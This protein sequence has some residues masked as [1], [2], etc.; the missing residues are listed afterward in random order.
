[1]AT[2]A[3]AVQTGTTFSAL[4]H[5]NYRLYFTGQ[6]I[7]SAGMWMQSIAQGWLVF[8]LT[9]SEMALGIVA[10]A[11]GI[12]SLLLSPFAGVVVDRFP[13]RTLL[14]CT[15]TVQMTLAFVLAFLVFSGTV[16]VWHIVLMAFLLGV[17]NSV[18]AP[19]RQSFVKD[20]VGSEDMSSGITLNSM[21]INGARIVGPAAAGVLLV[22]VGA[23]WCFLINGVSVLATL[24]CMAIMHVPKTVPGVGRGSPIRQMREGVHF[25][26]YHQT[27]LPL[28]LLA[29]VVSVFAVNVMTLLPAFAHNVLHA[30]AH[31]LSM[32]TSAQGF[33]AL[34]GALL[35]GMLVRR[36]GRGRVTILTMFMLSAG[37]VVLALTSHLAASAF[38]TA[39]I[40]FSM[41][42]FYVNINCMI[43]NEVPDAFRGRVMA[44][45]TLTFLGLTPLGALAVG[46][47]ADH[48][49]TPGALALYGL[50]NGVLGLL[51]VLRWRAVERIA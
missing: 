26:R 8:Q 1:M 18:D 39:L 49:G 40:G 42:I 28:L 32:L 14:L 15:Q 20:M 43:Q 24:F 4:R 23:A 30:P 35:L 34:C 5:P 2:L 13:R 10:C 12:A 3:Q 33:G 45:Y 16:Q 31:G 48:I 27:I 19:A 7:A 11:A 29:T 47:I 25:S 6:L 51:I 9:H 46:W 17:S 38:L 21:M 41:V 44:L 37:L 36:Y 22:T 50:L